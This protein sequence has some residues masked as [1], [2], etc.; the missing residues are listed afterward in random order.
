[1]NH[2]LYPD[3]LLGIPLRGEALASDLNARAESLSS[4]QEAD[5]DVSIV[6]RTLNEA[7]RL[8]SLLQDI[9]GQA[10]TGAVEVVVVDNESTDHT[11]EVARSYGAQVVSMARGEFTYPKSMNMG[12]EAAS[13]DATL[14][15]VGH[16]RLSNTQLLRAGSRHMRQPNVAGTYGLTL[17]NDNASLNEVVLFGLPASLR[18]VQN[19]TK[20]SMGVMGAT[21]AF[22]SRDIW[23][24]LGK[25][26]ERYERGG[27]DITMARKMLT[28]G[29]EL[30]KDP[31]LAVHHTHGLGPIDSIKQWYQW[32]RTMIGPQSLNT[33][34]LAGRRPDLSFD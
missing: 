6:I 10:F 28:N 24:Q 29:H 20:A 13:Y 31:A 34:R 26:D 32:A 18:N 12:M 23:T 8:E 7:G 19:I 30:I 15:T 11:P 25:F 27:E 3:L 9:A 21:N 22:F 4:S 1:M 16:V 33:N 2:L 14:L 17:P 5:G